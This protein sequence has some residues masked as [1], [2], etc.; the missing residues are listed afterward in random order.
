MD[1]AELSVPS[2]GKAWLVASAD[3]SARAKKTDEGVLQSCSFNKKARVDLDLFQFTFIDLLLFFLSGP[4]P[5]QLIC[6]TW[7]VPDKARFIKNNK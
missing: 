7:L 6:K 5:A 4:R 3:S 1:Q 2:L